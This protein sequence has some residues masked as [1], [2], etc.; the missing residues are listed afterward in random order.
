[1]PDEQ[2]LRHVDSSGVGRVR[3]FWSRAPRWPIVLLAIAAVVGWFAELRS[4]DVAMQNP[5]WLSV[6]YMPAMLL[7]FA[8]IAGV[9]WLQLMLQL[10]YEGRQGMERPAFRR[11]RIVW[12]WLIFAAG[13]TLAMIPTQWPMNVGFTASRASFDRL[14]NEAISDPTHL[15]RFSGRWAGLYQVSAVRVIGRTVVFYLDKDGG[16]YG[17]ARVPG[18]TNDLVF[19][20]Q[21]LEFNPNYWHD[22]PPQIAL[23]D[24]VGDRIS[25]D[26]FVVYSDYRHSKRGWS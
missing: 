7:S 8:M 13:C 16:I 24:P 4:P 5:F 1:M 19:N 22:F 14:A 9:R 25:G 12:L 26:W 3:R 2:Q 6:G 15:D 20:A 10:H 21:G 17:F 11:R 23:A 18:A